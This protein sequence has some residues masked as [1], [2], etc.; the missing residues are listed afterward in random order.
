MNSSILTKQLFAIILIFLG[1]QVVSQNQSKPRN[2]IGE[3]L[4]VYQL[5]N[6]SERVYLHTDKSKMIPGETLWFSAYLVQG[7]LHFFSKQSKVLHVDLINTHNQVI[8]SKTL[9]IENGVGS[10][11]I[12]FPANS[13]PGEYVLRAYTNWMRNFDDGLFF[14]KKIEVV[15]TTY[16][17]PAMK[18]DEGLNISFYPEGGQLVQELNGRVAFKITDKNGNGV[19]ESLEGRIVDS[20]KNTVTFFKS[21]HGGM[22]T[23]FL[24][25]QKG[26]R[27][28]AVLPDGSV[29]SLP[30]P[31]DQGLS[32]IA[33]NSGKNSIKLT[34]LASQNYVGKEVHLVGTLE[35]QLVFDNT[36]NI[37]DGRLEFEIPKSDLPKGILNLSL[38]D[39][40]KAPKCTRSIF[41]Q[42]KHSLYVTT[43]LKK[44]L[45]DGEKKMIL[46]VIVADKDGNPISTNLSLAITDADFT[47]KM[48]E[49]KNLASNF[50][51][52]SNS[53][54]SPE[55]SASF[56]M[57]DDRTS[58][59][60][61]DLLMLTHSFKSP[62][63]DE[64]M[65]PSNSVKKFNVTK[66]L[67]ISG[68]ARWEDGL[69]IRNKELR[70][71]S[72]SKGDIRSYVTATDENGIFSID[73][74]DEVGK[75]NVIFSV[76][77]KNGKLLPSKVTL[78]ESKPYLPVPNY[79]FPKL[80]EEVFSESDSASQRAFSE[81]QA[82]YTMFDEDATLLE[83]IMVEAEKLE[84]E[85]TPSVF[86]VNPSATRVIDE[87]NLDRMDYL[88][89]LN[90][91]PGVRYTGRGPTATVTIQGPVSF[92]AT[93]PLWV[94]D[95]VILTPDANNGN[96]NVPSFLANLNPA[97]VE[98]IEVVKGAEAAIFGSRGGAGV[99]II[100]TRQGGSRY[101][102]PTSNL[103]VKGHDA[104]KFFDP[105]S[106]ENTNR[107][108]L[109]WN[110][111]VKTDENGSANIEFLNISNAET[112]QVD[113]Q[114]LSDQGLMGVYL[115]TVNVGEI[116]RA[117]PEK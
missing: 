94:L 30:K 59:L 103:E 81:D 17:A 101:N 116:D 49:E 42:N 90:T 33:N 66:G 110:P 29:H 89:V 20:K 32:L 5:N 106:P 10:G 62:D 11:A 71:V 63:W 79:E 95:G 84:V 46:E 77:G 12:T 31:E 78:N 18:V 38:L 100:Y 76:Y 45:D 52:E 1:L 3:A 50:L 113:I 86:G 25:P 23:F 82:A 36:Y 65:N 75:A 92:S 22:G 40:S 15:L 73:S 105:A 83:E 64:V 37:E 21:L 57:N 117:D 34:L 43:S 16:E 56:V 91:I 72:Y 39:G 69:P 115:E 80:E 19:S 55:K 111:Q 27:Y 6:F 112:I 68:T 61:A 54:Q 8:V 9:K 26:D 58:I 28:M 4:K 97:D 7:P 35:N 70:A 88:Q 99:I 14:S 60:K 44:S 108:T 109:Y 48:D 96:S 67:T 107:F 93:S 2:E 104:P 114:G 98:R 102:P 13:P 53:I 47:N 41:I 24:E 85:R 51:V 87:N 74:F